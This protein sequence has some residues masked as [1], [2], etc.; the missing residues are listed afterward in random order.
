LA[1]EVAAYATV[2]Q[3]LHTRNGR[4]RRERSVYLDIAI[5]ILEERE[6]VRRGQ[7]GDKV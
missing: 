2:E 5:L 3:L 1:Y 7:L 4:R 6:L